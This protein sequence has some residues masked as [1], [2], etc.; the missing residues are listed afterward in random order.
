[1]DLGSVKRKLES[2]QYTDYKDVH[3]DVLQMFK[4]C[5]LYDPTTH[6]VVKMAKKL[7]QVAEKRL[8]LK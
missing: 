2:D 3:T 8:I 5:Y 6:S 1:M 7:E 4:N